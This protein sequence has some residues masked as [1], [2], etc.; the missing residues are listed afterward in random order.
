MA[1]IVQY[2]ITIQKLKLT[3][4]TFMKYNSSLPEKEIPSALNKMSN[5]K[6]LRNYGLT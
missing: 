2:V 5:D 1:R 4:G 3:E 6:S